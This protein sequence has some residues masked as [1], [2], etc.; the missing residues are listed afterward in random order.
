DVLS[1]WGYIG[2]VPLLTGLFGVCPGY[3][4][5]G[6]STTKKHGDDSAG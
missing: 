1:P 4:L 2:I 5:I 6:V 3:S